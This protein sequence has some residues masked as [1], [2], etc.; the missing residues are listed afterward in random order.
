MTENIETIESIEDYK[1]TEKWSDYVEPIDEEIEE[2]KSEEEFAEYFAIKKTK[3]EFFYA[4]G[5]QSYFDSFSGIKREFNK[6]E[7]NALVK[8]A[9]GDTKEAEEATFSLIK[10]NIRLVIKCASVFKKTHSTRLEVSDLAEEGVKG[11]IKAIERYDPKHSSGSSFGTFAYPYIRC[12]LFKSY[13]NYRFIKIPFHRYDQISNYKKLENEY[14]SKGEELTDEIV[15]K[16]MKW[17]K[18]TLKS[19]KENIKDDVLRLDGLTYGESDA[20][21]ESMIPDSKSDAPSK[22]F[23]DSNAIDTLMKIMFDVLD[24]REQFV[25]WN[26]YMNETP[27]RLNQIGSLIG[28]TR[29]RARQLKLSGLTKLKRHIAEEYID[30]S[31]NTL[32]NEVDY[33]IGDKHYNFFFN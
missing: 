25:L 31:A 27:L 33:Q 22:Q 17:T 21:W 10:D 32:D 6:E 4:G 14:K 19:V 2:P 15:L 24:H 23:E 18:E 5:I 28:V 7:T 30:Q 8:V 1:N 11:L 16:E 13:K 9:Q 29:E 3:R 26:Y 20:T 12:E